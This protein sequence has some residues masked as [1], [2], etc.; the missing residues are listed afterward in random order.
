MFVGVGQ[1]F[2]NNICK[3][4]LYW[5]AFALVDVIVQILLVAS[6]ANKS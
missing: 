3:I 2:A 1:T 4:A 6:A 5:I